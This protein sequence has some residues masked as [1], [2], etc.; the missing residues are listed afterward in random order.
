MTTM[1]TKKKKILFISWTLGLGHITRDLEIA[2]ELRKLI[3]DVELSWL[4]CSPARE[5][6]LDAGENVLP[7]SQQL[8]NETELIEQIAE[9]AH[10][11]NLLKYCVRWSGRTFRDSD[12]SG[13]IIK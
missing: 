10:R 11:L 5:L 9:K 1:T 2:R 6:L 3:P 7:E 13:T 8:A 4:A 12:C